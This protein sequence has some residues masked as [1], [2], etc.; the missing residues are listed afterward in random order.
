MIMEKSGWKFKNF[1]KTRNLLHIP[2]FN[3]K[4]FEL[5][6]KFYLYFVNIF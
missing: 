6:F 2:V 5:I 3:F 1:L 4:F